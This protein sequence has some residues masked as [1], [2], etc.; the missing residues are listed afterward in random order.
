LGNI[1]C[2]EF[3]GCG[4]VG[5]PFVEKWTLVKT[6]NRSGYIVASDDYK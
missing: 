2:D 4:T 1:Y 5:V 6:K 3:C